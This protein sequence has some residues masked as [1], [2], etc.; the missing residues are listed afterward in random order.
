MYALQ[1]QGIKHEPLPQI[2]PLA[3]LFAAE[4]SVSEISQNQTLLLLLCAPEV[5]I[6]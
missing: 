1:Q 4:I 6:C 5:L 2:F 3:L